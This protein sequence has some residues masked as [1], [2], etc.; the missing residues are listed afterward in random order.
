MEIDRQ[1]KQNIDRAHNTALEILQL[2]HGLLESTTQ[3]LLEKEVLEG[4]ELQG[5][6]ALV[7]VP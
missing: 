4:D 7:Q 1:V 3:I 2:N 5:I 6:L